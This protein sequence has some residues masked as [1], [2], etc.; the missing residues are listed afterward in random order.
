MEKGK[1]MYEGKAK[2]ID[3]TDNPDLLIPYFKGDAEETCHEV[4]H[5]VC[6]A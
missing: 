1:L 3:S 6:A 4:R 5:R 2:G